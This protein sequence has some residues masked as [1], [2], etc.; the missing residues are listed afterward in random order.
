MTSTNVAQSTSLEPPQE[1]FS[2]DG[3]LVLEG[4]L[5][6]DETE[7]LLSEVDVALRRPRHPSCT[8]PHNT[9]LPLRWSDTTVRVLLESD[10]RIQMVRDATGA[11]DLRWI[12]AYISIK[13]ARSG[14]LGWHQD[15][16][17][18]DHPVSF[19]RPAPQIA[20]LCYLNHTDRESNGALRLLPGSHLRS[21][22]IHVTLA[23][24]HEA[25]TE[26]LVPGH[27]A[28][29]DHPAQ[30]TLLLAAG[31]AVVID[32]RL[33]HGT[34]ANTS[35]LRR[36]CVILNFTP[37]WRDLPDDIRAHLINHSA[38]PAKDEVIPAVPSWESGLL[39]R[40]DGVR[41]D[42]HLNR[43]PPAQFETCE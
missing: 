41:R 39:P 33:L 19:R 42:L 31:N 36:D 30:V 7:R 17:C 38:Q 12:S 3:F 21:S 4:F 9:L 37:S 14:P 15:W 10:C 5:A 22:A 40:F 6:E 28:L 16:W 11:N 13:D 32:Y 43:F 25:A 29:S 8:R 34:H 27:P 35:E 2:R 24:A 1:Y 23:E 26:G 20:V 18:W